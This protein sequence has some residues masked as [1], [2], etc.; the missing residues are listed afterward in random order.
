MPSFFFV[1][2]G[3]RMMAC[4]WSCRRGWCIFVLLSRSGMLSFFSLTMISL[5][6]PLLL[7]VLVATTL[8]DAFT[9]GRIPSP[10]A[11]PHT[12]SALFRQYDVANVRQRFTRLHQSSFAADG[13]EYSS[14]DDYN[15]NDN[16]HKTTNNIHWD[17]YPKKYR[18]F[19]RGTDT[20]FQPNPE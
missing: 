9:I 20:R 7:Q 17:C 5:L 12:S 18:R 13:S 1:D 10:S 19:R 8:C 16:D 2:D 6:L 4:R 11:L 15:N 14:N 3:C